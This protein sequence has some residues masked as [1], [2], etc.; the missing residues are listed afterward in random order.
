MP[1]LF[2]YMHTHVGFMEQI[3]FI[4]LSL[5]LFTVSANMFSQTAEAD[6]LLN[7]IDKAK[8]EKRLELIYQYSLLYEEDKKL[9]EIANWLEKEAIDEDNDI[10]KANS[11]SLKVR[12]FLFEANLDS[13]LYYSNK[14]DALSK[15]DEQ[16]EDSRFLVHYYIATMYVSK[17]YYDL[18]IHELNGLLNNN[19]K[20]MIGM[21]LLHINVWALHILHQRGLI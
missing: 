4:I 9:L 10:Y 21:K 19:R 14:I 1:C 11:Y 16:I 3:K 6:S 2:R 8:G 18:A 13:V 15:K 12:F 7:E 20:K 17:G 5:L